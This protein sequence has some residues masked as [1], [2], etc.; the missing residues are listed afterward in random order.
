MATKY[1]YLLIIVLWDIEPCLV[2]DRHS[3][4]YS[5]NEQMDDPMANDPMD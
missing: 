5:F 4:I 2:H 1:I 3:I